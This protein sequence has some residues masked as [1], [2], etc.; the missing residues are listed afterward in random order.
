MTDQRIAVITGASRGL[1]RATAQ[2]L[3]DQ[4]YQVVVTARDASAA[5]AT[6]A[7]IGHGAAAHQLDV[8]SDEQVATLARWLEQEYGKVD[9]LVNN[10]GAI[11][12]RHDDEFGISAATVPASTVLAAVNTNSLGAY[13][14]TQALAPLLVASGDARVVNVTSGM[15]QLSEMGPGYPAYRISKTALNAVTRV[16]HNE[17]SH[18]GVTVNSVC[19]GWVKTDMGGGGASLEIEEGIDTIVWL[20]TLPA[21]GPS[22]GFFKRRRQLDW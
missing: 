19:P 1:G 13:R 3:A 21:G 7:D 8:S 14:V 11:F 9:V 17:L 20:A 6:A 18:G 4:G 15:G 2:A 10:A 5:S 22:G 12:E 16:F